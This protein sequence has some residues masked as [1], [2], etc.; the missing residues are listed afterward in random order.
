MEDREIERNRLAHG[1][2]LIHI[3]MSIT[4]M[5]EMVLSHPSFIVESYFSGLLLM[6]GQTI[7]R[8]NS[9]RLEHI[10]IPSD[11]NFTREYKMLLCMIGIIEKILGLWDTNSFFLLLM[12]RVLGL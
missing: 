10:N 8:E 2:S 11:Q 5:S 12:W 4:F 3:I 1:W 6:H 7:N 9:T